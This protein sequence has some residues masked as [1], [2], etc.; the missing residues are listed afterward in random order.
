MARLLTPIRRAGVSGEAVRDD[1]GA[2]GWAEFGARVNAWIHLLRSRGLATG[3]R[4][5]FLLGNRRETFEAML[6]CLHTGLVVVPV[7]A[8]LT[9]GEAR[10]IMGDAACRAV[11]TEPRHAAAA[12]AA[13]AGAGVPATNALLVGAGAEGACRGLVAV[14]PLLAGA[15]VEE[16]T[17]QRCGALLLYTSGTTGAPKGVANGLFTMGAPM[18]RVADRLAVLG[19][20]FGVPEGRRALLVGPWYHSAQLFFSLLPLVRGGG[21]VIRER[22]DAAATLAD[23]DRW[24]IELAH[25]VPT[26]LIRLLR[27]DAATRGAFRGSS[28]LRVWHG[29]GPCPIEVKRRMIEWWGPVLVEYYGAT[30]AGIVAMIDSAEWLARPG[31]VGRPVP[32]TEVVVVGA[33][34]RE[35]GPGEEGTVYV[36]R[37][38]GAGFHYHNAAEDT[39][40]AYRGP[41]E[42]TVGDLGRLDEDGYLYLTGRSPDVIVTGGVN[43]YPAEVESVLLNHPGVRDAVVVGVPDEE[44]GERVMAVVEL[45]A[46]G[47]ARHRA[48]EALDRHCR[49]ALAGFKVPR[50]YRFV[51]R[52]PRDDAGKV[53][54][55]ALRDRLRIE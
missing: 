44:F 18:S 25:L 14:E 4:V 37:R 17:D 11:V 7:N 34:G 9:A 19:R 12:M 27:L 13:A 48:P 15:G 8:R 1:R 20:L 40:R 46:G 52:L 45:A 51:D 42:F 49:S 39:R 24:R 38:A 23:V 29:G 54:R 47:P 41:G 28:L 2:S 50:A 33:D 22:F 16:P 43:V 26:Q 32:S 21:L 5:A 10:H 35:L 53:S 36:R 30:E 31:S 3:D 6:A 55:R